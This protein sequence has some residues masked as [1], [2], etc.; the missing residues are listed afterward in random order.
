MITDAVIMTAPATASAG[1]N[2]GRP[3]QDAA[4]PFSVLPRIRLRPSAEGW[5][6]SASALRT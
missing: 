6:E 2:H 4:R 5:T 1:R 3:N